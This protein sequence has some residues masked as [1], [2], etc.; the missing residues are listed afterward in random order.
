MKRHW[1]RGVLL[2]LSLALLVSGGVALAQGTLSVDKTCV[3][4]VPE[5]YRGLPHDQIPYDPYKMTITGEGWGYSPK[6]AV[7][8]AAQIQSVYREIRWPKGYVDDVCL[9]LG[10]GGS[11]VWWPGGTWFP[12][13]LCPDE[14]TPTEYEA[15]VS[16][17]CV[18]A[19]GEVEFYV[20]DDTGG[21]SVSLLVVED[22]A[23]A[24]FVPEPGSILLLGSGLAGLAGYAT[25]R[26]RSGQALGWRTRE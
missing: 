25:L 26:L 14:V 1:L 21:R 20:E 7:L 15:G 13:P 16:N 23:A 17:W 22:C 18:P 5:T 9:P 3:E 2:G 6:C 10:P 8:D 19:L 11:F 12:C 24:T 4:C